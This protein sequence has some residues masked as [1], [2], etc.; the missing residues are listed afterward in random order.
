MCQ[1]FE[2][3]GGAEFAD[4]FLSGF[5]SDVKVFGDGE[6]CAAVE[7]GGEAIE[8]CLAKN[9]DGASSGVGVG[10][11]KLTKDV[12]GVLQQHTSHDERGAKISV[13]ADDDGLD[14]LAVHEAKR[15]E[16]HGDTKCDKT[17]ATDRSDNI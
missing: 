13:V 8:E 17:K 14:G 2:L 12:G 3:A 7:F 16:N 11:W 6:I 1:V 10:G 5:G 4:V 15:S 9:S